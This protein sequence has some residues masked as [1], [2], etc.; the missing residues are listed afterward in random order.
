MATEKSIISATSN[1]SLMLLSEINPIVMTTVRKN[2]LFY[3]KSQFSPQG[4]L[5]S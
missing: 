5:T 4:I 2:Q 3:V 1:V